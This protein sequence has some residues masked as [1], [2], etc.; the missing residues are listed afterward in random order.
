MF[1]YTYIS[2]EGYTI[3]IQVHL[4]VQQS[5][6][7]Y[8]YFCFSRN[9]QHLVHREIIIV[10]MIIVIHV[11]VIVIVY[12]PARLRTRHSRGTRE[13]IAIVFY[14]NIIVN[15]ECQS[16][17][18][19]NI[20][21][22]IIPA[23]LPREQLTIS[24]SRVFPLAYARDPLRDSPLKPLYLCARPRREGRRTEPRV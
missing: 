6:T 22:R 5:N 3:L 21:T 14:M 12:P 19:L 7:L 20:S 4:T 15:S 16:P 8:F 18:T 13:I 10:R 24:R 9:N 23:F 17:R 2:Y 11:I 1:Y